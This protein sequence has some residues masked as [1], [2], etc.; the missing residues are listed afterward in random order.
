[1]A[2]AHFHMTRLRRSLDPT[3]TVH[4]FLALQRS[5]KYSELRI[6]PAG[7]SKKTFDI[8]GYRWPSRSERRR[9]GVGTK[10]PQFQLGERVSVAIRR[11]RRQGRIVGLF[12]HPASGLPGYR[13]KLDRTSREGASTVFVGAQSLMSHVDNPREGYTPNQVRFGQRGRSL[14]GW[15]HKE[16][17]TRYYIAYKDGA[18]VRYVWRRKD[19]VSFMAKRNNP[20]PETANPGDHFANPDGS[21]RAKA[22]ALSKKFHG[23]EP[24]RIS[25]QRMNFPSAWTEI[26]VCSQLNYVTDKWDGKV[27]E[28]FHEF[29]NECRIF[30]APNV[31]PSGEALL[32]IKGNFEIRPEGITG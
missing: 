17:P 22:V 30:A 21:D 4:Q 8:V 28:Y 1:M 23:F 18:Q 13:I 6:L 20:C 2:G 24:R 16:T 3:K 32:L 15:I 7:R 12:E 11:K 25:K 29:V 10:N 27:R 19:K 14:V 31:Q 5:G 9:R 26:G